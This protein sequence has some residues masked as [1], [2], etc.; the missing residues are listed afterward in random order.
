MLSEKKGGLLELI[1]DA[2]VLSSRA[3]LSQ[4]RAAS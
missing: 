2:E 4:L 3:T 1:L